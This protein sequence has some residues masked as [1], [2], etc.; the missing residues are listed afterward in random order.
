MTGITPSS[1]LGDD[2]LS[3][4]ARR[5]IYV[6]SLDALTAANIHRYIDSKSPAEVLKDNLSG[7]NSKIKDPEVEKIF[8]ITIANL[9]QS[10]TTKGLFTSEIIDYIINSIQAISNKKNIEDENVLNFAEEISKYISIFHKNYYEESNKFSNSNLKGLKNISNLSQSPS[11]RDENRKE[12][13]NDRIAAEVLNVVYSRNSLTG[14]EFSG[15]TIKSSQDPQI[16]QDFENVANYL[17]LGDKKEQLNKNS[18]DINVNKNIASPTK[19]NPSL[20]VILLKNN[21]LRSGTKN[22]TELSAFL[23]SVSNLEFSKAY[24]YF[25][26]TFIL[27]SVSKKDSKN[28]FKTATLNQFMFGSRTDNITENYN[29]FEGRITKNGNESISVEANLSIFMTPQTFV[30]MNEKVGHRDQYNDE[31]KRLRITSVHDKTQPFMTLKSFEIDLA[32][33]EGLMYFKSG[34]LSL[35]LHDRTRMTDIAPFIKPDLF[36]AF[37]A[38]IAVEYGWRHGDAN[39]KN[40]NGLPINPIGDFLNSSVCMEKYMITNSQFSI[41]SSGEVEIN[42]AIAMKGPIDIRQT[43]IT[44]YGRE[45]LERTG[46]N[47]AYQ[48]YTNALNEVANN[49]NEGSNTRPDSFLTITSGLSNLFRGQYIDKDKKKDK[50]LL[51][52]AYELLRETSVV[53]ETLQTGSYDRSKKEVAFKFKT[54][55]K[56]RAYKKLQGKINPLILKYCGINLKSLKYNVTKVDTAGYL[57][58]SAFRELGEAIAGISTQINNILSFNNKVGSS[59]KSYTNN[60]IGGL[61]KNDMFMDNALIFNSKQLGDAYKIEENKYITLGSFIT[62]LVGTQMTSTLK[63]DEIQI[64]FHNINNRAGMCSNI[65]YPER[66]DKSSPISLASLLINKQLLEDYLVDLFQKNVSITVES[67]ISQVLSNFIVK[68]DN[69][70]YGLGRHFSRKD[71]KSPVKPISEKLKKK[72]NISGSITDDLNKFYYG[73]GENATALYDSEGVFIPPTVQLSFDA[74]TNVLDQ[75]RTICRIS[76]YDRNDNPYQIVSNSFNNADLKE[77]NNV[78]S[79]LRVHNE[80]KN[81]EGQANKLKDQAKKLKGKKSKKANEQKIKSLGN[82]IAAKTKIEKEIFD[83]LTGPDGVFE[84]FEQEGKTL[85]RF[86]S[87]KGF[88]DIKQKSKQLMP[89]ATF[90]SEHSSLVNAS[91]STVNEANLNTVYITRQNRNDVV[92]LNTNVFVDMPLRILPAAASIETLGCPWVGFGQ[93]IFLDFETG[94]TIDNAYAVTSIKHVLTPGSFKTQL[95]LSYGDTYGKYEGLA[96]GFSQIVEK[97]GNTEDEST[98][99]QKEKTK[100]TIDKK[101]E[102]NQKSIVMQAIEDVAALRSKE[103]TEKIKE[104]SK[105]EFVSRRQTVVP[106]VMDKKQKSLIKKASKEAKINKAKEITLPESKSV[107][108]YLTFSSFF[109]V[110]EVYSFLN[111][112]EKYK[113]QSIYKNKGVLKYDGETSTTFFSPKSNFYDL[114][115]EYISIIKTIQK[116]KNLHD[117]FENKFKIESLLTSKESENKTKSRKLDYIENIISGIDKNLTEN[118]FLNSLR[119]EISSD[120]LE[121]K[122]LNSLFENIIEYEPIIQIIVSEA[123]DSTERKIS[124]SSGKSKSNEVENEFIKKENFAIEEPKYLEAEPVF[125]RTITLYTDTS[126]DFELSK[127]SLNGFDSIKKLKSFVEKEDNYKYLTKLFPEFLKTS[128]DL[129]NVFNIKVENKS[130]GEIVVYYLKIPNRGIILDINMD[131]KTNYTGAGTGITPIIK[132]NSLTRKELTERSSVNSYIIEE[133]K[134]DSFYADY[135]IKSVENTLNIFEKLLDNITLNDYYDYD[136]SISNLFDSHYVKIEEVSSDSPRLS[137]KELTSTLSNMISDN[138][139]LLVSEE[140]INERIEFDYILY[141]LNLQKA[142]YVN[143]LISVSS[144]EEFI[145]P[146]S[147]TRMKVLTG[148]DSSNN[149]DRFLADYPSTSFKDFKDL[150]NNIE[151]K[152]EYFDIPMSETIGN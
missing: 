144:P 123:N 99:V 149:I 107:Y 113:A 79:M 34:R 83:K 2:S 84:M 70:C 140:T 133:I 101:Q 111:F 27:P 13:I 24:P 56:S 125:L 135:T 114:I 17:N 134:E 121:L 7:I 40:S 127:N 150:E 115:K 66:D 90:A 97:F 88:V 82:K 20:S 50:K 55:Q 81:L 139:I 3:V 48:V 38:E 23:N 30:N 110:N 28:I 77:F 116:K 92:N 105:S 137:Y 36:G 69:P 29:S 59:I 52:D 122:Y 35:V 86:K 44:A 10:I 14:R 74:L 91:V 131:L 146:G 132:T 143:S 87:G 142:K 45:K 67:L 124:F 53:G 103:G 63:Y 76:V 12:S 6:N 51:N 42:L 94:T 58:A 60:L 46:F 118:A 100:E 147:K 148:K 4:E 85:F 102:E 71:F 15:Q 47:N 65:E 126:S 152:I 93:Y 19:K 43:E 54:S 16:L 25:N 61:K 136:I 1:I 73:T 141:I 49:L 106:K 21:D 11:A 80:I 18:K 129:Y 31:D 5:Q 112:L 108:T 145:I 9:F 32:P 37:G 95:S 68:K 130:T 104:L 128:N 151:V 117:F 64:V 138:K 75:E 41:L 119:K 39:K 33:T 109:G 89:T 8:Y 98:K 72:N 22:A 26:A 96:D 57:L 78:K 120:V 62:S